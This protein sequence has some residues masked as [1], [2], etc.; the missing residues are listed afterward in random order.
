MA[1]AKQELSDK[2]LELISENAKRSLEMIE[3]FRE[4][5]R[6]VRVAKTMTD[7]SSLI[8]R[9]V[10][11]MTRSD[12]VTVDLHLGEGLD[13]VSVDSGLIRRVLENLVRNGVEAMPDGGRLTVS[14]R[15]E[16]GN[17]VIEVGDTGVGVEEGDQKHLF[18][19]LFSR[20]KGGLGLGLYFVRMAVDAHGGEVSFN[21]RVGAGTTFTILLPVARCLVPK[22]AT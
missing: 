22:L 8:K 19:P 15:R 2:M 13:D 16:D 11:E 9:T 1:R 12:N 21:S 18:E 3:E 6:E 7:L 4:G 10:E 5:T 20:K 17:A 14:A